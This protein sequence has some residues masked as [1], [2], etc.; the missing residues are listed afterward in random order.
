M[1]TA[2]TSK[3]VWVIYLNRERD[4]TYFT[5]LLYTRNKLATFTARADLVPV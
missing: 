1:P 3:T 4:V 5:G 2:L